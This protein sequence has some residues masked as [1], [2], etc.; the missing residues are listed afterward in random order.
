M[1]LRLGSFLDGQSCDA[2]WTLYG[3][4]GRQLEGI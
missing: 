1:Q 4:V 2:H 3:H